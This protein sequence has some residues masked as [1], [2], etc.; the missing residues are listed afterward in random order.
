M[1]PSCLSAT[2]WNKE[3]TR[4]PPCRIFYSITIIYLWSVHFNSWV[5]IVRSKNKG[6]PYFVCFSCDLTHYQLTEFGH[7]HSSGQ[8]TDKYLVLSL[9]E[10]GWDLPKLANL[11][12]SIS[13]IVIRYVICIL[14]PSL[15]VWCSLW[16]VT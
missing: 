10:K 9:M 1:L 2:W 11:S 8:H 16:I 7:S 12:P 6:N 14:P 13:A 4:K 3:I 15:S 5:I